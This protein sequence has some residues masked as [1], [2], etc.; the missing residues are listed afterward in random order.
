MS[1]RLLLKLTRFCDGDS[2]SLV[3]ALG[4]DFGLALKKVLSLPLTS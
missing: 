3:F 1:L 2:C 4:H